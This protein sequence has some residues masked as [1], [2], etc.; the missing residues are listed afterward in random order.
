MSDIIEMPADIEPAQI[1]IEPC[2]LCGCIIE[3]FEELIYLR[4]ADLITQ[5]ELADVRDAWRH[6]GEKRPG[7]GPEPAPAPRSQA[8]ITPQSVVDAFLY[9]AHNHDADY[10]AKWL[11]NH[12]QDVATLTKLWEAK[13]GLS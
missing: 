13:N 7:P 6:T 10:V 11:A 3:D 4:A 12:P 8:Y 2:E 9:V 1:E 5:W